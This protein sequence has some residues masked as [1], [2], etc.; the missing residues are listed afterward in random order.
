MS[1]V[2]DML[3]DDLPAIFTEAGDSV[4]YAGTGI[5]AVLGPETVEERTDG[6]GVRR[7]VRV[8]EM[9]VQAADVAA[10]AV[11]DAVVIGSNTYAVGRVLEPEGELL[12]GE[13]TD[14]GTTREVAMSETVERVGQGLEE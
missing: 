2:T 3:T 8:R 14:G 12:L 4:T 5:T 13:K 1:D 7:E 10:P 11:A 9:T 6:D